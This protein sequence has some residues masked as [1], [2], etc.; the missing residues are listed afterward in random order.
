MLGYRYIWHTTL[1]GILSIT[2]HG[3]LPYAY[4]QLAFAARLSIICEACVRGLIDNFSCA[5]HGG[6]LLSLV[7]SLYQDCPLRLGETQL[8]APHKVLRI[9]GL[10]REALQE[11]TDLKLPLKYRRSG[12]LLMCSIKIVGSNN[13]SITYGRCEKRLNSNR[14]NASC[15]AGRRYRCC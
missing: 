11:R 12:N 8:V 9:V 3:N 14:G 2:S 15:D 10:D 5:T 7:H 13:M 1:P 4:H 6:D